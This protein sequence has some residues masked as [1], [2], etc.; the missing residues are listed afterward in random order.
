MNRKEREGYSSCVPQSVSSGYRSPVL[1]APLFLCRSR[2]RYRRELLRPSFSRSSLSFPPRSSSPT[3]PTIC[4]PGCT[5]RCSSLSLSLSLFVFDFSLRLPSFF[6][7]SAIIMLPEV[8]STVRDLR[9][10][11]PNSHL[12]FTSCSLDFSLFA[13]TPVFPSSSRRWSLI[14]GFAFKVAI[15]IHGS[16][17]C[18]PIAIFCSS[19]KKN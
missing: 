4:H 9:K 13:S 2:R 17:P 16:N 11:S 15:Y 18:S 8:K 5:F 6:P 7:S 1:S 12:R 3:S 14:V 10:F 19:L